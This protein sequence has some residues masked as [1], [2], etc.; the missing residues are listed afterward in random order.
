M[1]NVLLAS[2]VISAQL[3]GE[4]S[5]IFLEQ[6]DCTSTD[7]DILQCN[8]FSAQ[9]IHSCTH[10]QDV[11]VRCTGTKRACNLLT[12]SSFFTTDIDECGDGSGPCMHVCKNTIGSFECSC[13][14]GFLL[15]N[16]GLSCEGNH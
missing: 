7:T 14:T 6:L 10:M 9:G 5:P 11:T 8:S 2:Q 12:N 4:N 1:V 15:Q 13:N 3:P 16:D